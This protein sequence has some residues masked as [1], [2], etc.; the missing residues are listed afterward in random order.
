MNSSVSP[1]RTVEEAASAATRI[2][3]VVLT[4]LAGGS[5]T[6]IQIARDVRGLLAS[7]PTDDVWR[8]QV[9]RL[10]VALSSSG[11]VQKKDQLFGLTAEGRASA[12]AFLGCKKQL[13]ESW[14]DLRDGPLVAKALGIAG[15]PQS[16][17]KALGKIDGLRALIVESR[18]K[19][20]LKGKPSASRI[21]QALA[22]V[23]LEKAFGNQVKNE[24]GTKSGLSTKA[25]RLLAGQLAKKPR[26]FGTDARLIAALAADATGVTRSD[27]GHLRLGVVKTFLGDLPARV[28]ASADVVAEQ[29]RSTVAPKPA[30]PVV[31]VDTLSPPKA[32]AGSRPNP[33]GF[34]RA[35]KAAAHA[36]AEGWPGNRRAYIAQVFDAVQERHSAWALAEI[37]FKAILVELHRTGL[38]S[39][40][41]AD[42]KDKN[43]LADVQRSAISYKNTVWHYIRVED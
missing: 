16:R 15:A 1:S 29:S 13:P 18:W 32:V 24:V 4:R 25:S 26:D 37:E 39:L 21:R 34:A 33:E 9:G 36:R 8:S 20:K 35:I 38:V 30:E 22:L 17:L 40:V 27:L 10:L 6:E 41:T 28:V 7:P 2:A 31:I 42:L 23:A 12:T 43:R 5:A 14:A 11:H 3:G 19:L